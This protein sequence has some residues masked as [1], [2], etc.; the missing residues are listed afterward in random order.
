VGELDL[1]RSA[2]GG[3]G[4]L[5]LIQGGHPRHPAKAQPGDLVERRARFGKARHAAR[6]RDHQTRG[7]CPATAGGPA[8]LGDE[9]GLG[10]L[11]TL[12]QGSAAE[13]G[14]PAGNH[15]AS[16]AE[17]ARAGPG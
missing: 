7:V 12:S 10:P 15:P 5:E 13:Q 8:G 4:L 1:H 16:L 6:N 9:P 11:D 3:E 17:I 2:A 14:Q